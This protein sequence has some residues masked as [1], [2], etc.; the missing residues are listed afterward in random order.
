MIVSGAPLPATVAQRSTWS[1]ASRLWRIGGRVQGVGFRPFVYRLA[2]RFGLRGWVRNSGGTVEICAQ[3]LAP[4]LEAFGRALL[5]QAPPA[6]RAQLLEERPAPEEPA[7]EFRILASASGAPARIHVP[8][9]LF[10]CDDCLAELRDPAARRYRYPFINCTQCGPRYTLIRAL[11]YDRL[12]TTMAGFALC[13]ACA[14][15]YANPLDRR[16]HAQPLACAVCGPQLRWYA[17]LGEPCEVG[18]NDAALSAATSA[19]HAGQIVAVRGIGGYHL[20]C[21]AGR[22]DAV[23]RLRAR[24]RRPTKPLALMVTWCG[25]DGLDQARSLVQLSP[26]QAAALTDAAR[27]I[28]LARRR[29]T[30][31]LAASIAPG[32]REV[33]LMLPYSPLHH[34]LLDAF[35]SALVATSGNLSGEPVLTEA[36]EAQVRLAGIADGFLHHDRPI[37]RPADDPVLRVV[38]GAARPL[39]LGRGTA[40]LELR[41]PTPIRVPTLAVGA[42]LK[43]TVALAWDERA[44]ISPHIGDLRSPRGRAVFTQIAEDLQRLYGVRAQCVVHD[45]HP[46]FP[47]T[48]WA[49][50]SGLPT[51]SV[52]HH[53]AHAAALAG[54]YPGTAPLLCFTW[55]GVGL[56]PDGTLWGGEGLLGRPGAWRRVASFRPFRLP[57]GERAAR[58]PWRSAQALCWESDTEWLDGA[59]FGGPLLRRAF[60]RGL[61]APM[62]S[63]VGRLFDAAAAL[64]GVCRQASYEGE[65]PMRLEALSE[66]IT[67]PPV[68]MP[69]T[70]DA[71]GTWRSDW[72]PLLPLLLDTRLPLALRAARFHISL[73]QTL[74]EQASALRRDCGVMRVGLAGGVFQNR[75]LSEQ[76]SAQL[77]A[78]G[79]EVLIPQ[80]LPVNDAAISYGQLVEMAASAA[81]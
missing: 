79:F 50:S 9:D 76:V 48:R 44:V 33:G 54:E 6:A 5:D 70:R 41:L 74:C 21:D 43:N 4:Q 24:K 52:W 15:E 65:A 77:R 17:D 11:P 18:G 61:N 2:H 3:G 80:Q 37:A 20:L 27:P 72:A 22:E 53:H 47:N 58:A 40:P 46:D 75:V 39:R 56:G 45:A 63:A 13:P 29:N 64:L 62:T 23:A 34:L 35:G 71:G 25:D 7:T 16:F 14:A 81:D 36:D 78:A 49:R 51:R 30:A 68:T 60:E 69:L 57:G 19:L 10:A 12:N 32:L 42:F 59:D 26:L 67:A 1:S 31:P 8:P 66:G 73:A 55:D 28:V 38:A